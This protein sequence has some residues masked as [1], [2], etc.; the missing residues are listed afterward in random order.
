MESKLFVL[1]LFIC[2]SFA[3]VSAQRSKN[4]DQTLIEADKCLKRLLYVGDWNLTIIRNEADLVAHCRDTKK[5]MACI[6]RYQKCLNSFPREVFNLM[7]RNA[8]QLNKERCED[9]KG[10][11]EFLKHI[12]CLDNSTISVNMC[13]D[14]VIVLLDYI[15][16]NIKGDRD[17]M[18]GSTCCAVHLGLSCFTEKVNENCA[19]KTG[20]ETSVYVTA[21]VNQMVADVF[22]LACAKVPD[23]A[24]C[25]KSNPELMKTYRSIIAPS[26]NIKRQQISPLIPL[27]KVVKKIEL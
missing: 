19:K 6:K 17:A 20:P 2:V 12:K 25:D 15:A 14:K 8:R 27:M 22:D 4:C 10:K 1:T 13:M 9:A 26:A 24:S 16:N 11:A 23:V 21:K 7:S 5:D 3:F 18:L